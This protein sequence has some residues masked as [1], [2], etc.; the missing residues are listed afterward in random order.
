[1]VNDMQTLCSNC[2]NCP[3][4]EALTWMRTC[5]K[6]HEPT[7]DSIEFDAIC[8]DF[9]QNV[10]II[11]GKCVNFTKKTQTNCNHWT[12]DDV[13]EMDETDAFPVK[14]RSA[15]KYCEGYSAN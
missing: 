11:C 1:M 3:N 9:E 13:M 2:K 6:G 12:E 14:L 5:N 4:P 15:F 8:D 7:D 10:N